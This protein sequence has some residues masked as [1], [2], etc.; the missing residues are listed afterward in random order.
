M[1]TANPSAAPAPAL[2]GTPTVRRRVIAMVYEAF[3]LIA[4]EA[5]AVFIYIFV[6]GNR[7]APAYRAGLMAF[8]FLVTAAYFVHAWSGSGFTLAMKTW[9]IKVVKVGAARVPLKNALVRY[10]LAWGWFAPALAVGAV[11]DLH[12]VREWAVVLTLGLVAWGATAFLD[13]DRQFLHDRI[14]GT[15][16]I[17]LPKVGKKK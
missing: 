14:A 8:L 16:L 4:V 12:H 3:L 2:I 9:R 13:K 5:L 6:T 7:Q 11:L 17:A 10:L 1:Q 15:R